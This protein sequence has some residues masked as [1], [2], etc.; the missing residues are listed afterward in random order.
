MVSLKPPILHVSWGDPYSP[1][2]LRYRSVSCFARF[3]MMFVLWY[4][5]RNLIIVLCLGM[6]L[7]TFKKK[8]MSDFPLNI[9]A[10]IGRAHWDPNFDPTPEYFEIQTRKIV[11]MME[12]ADEEANASDW[13]CR[14]MGRAKQQ[15]VCSHC[16][17]KQSL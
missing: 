3:F 6:N 16:E 5:L 14:I 8:P 7:Y 13:W 2:E 17:K 1:Y 12:G 11:A 9:E 10:S 15:A 4:H